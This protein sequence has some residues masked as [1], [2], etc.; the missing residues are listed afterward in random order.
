MN[1]DFDRPSA[2]ML[3]LA[4]ESNVDLKNEQML[5]EFKLVQMQNLEDI[6]RLRIGQKPL[7][8]EEIAVQ[9]EKLIAELKA[10]GKYKVIS[11]ESKDI[12]EKKET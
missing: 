10:K 3:Q 9:R 11:Q 1:L 2:R 12:V 5:Q 8:T 4:K 6:R 7:T